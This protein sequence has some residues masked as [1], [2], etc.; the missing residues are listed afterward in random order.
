MRG[1]DVLD[2]LNT[3][4]KLDFFLFLKF[5]TI[6]TLW[7]LWMTRKFELLVL[8]YLETATYSYEMCVWKL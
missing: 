1:F 8:L 6:W 3:L 4:D 7:T 2:A 5:W